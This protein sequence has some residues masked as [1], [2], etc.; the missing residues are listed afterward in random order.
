M[1]III[2]KDYRE[3]SQL[4]ANMVIKEMLIKE[5]II[6]G[7]ATGSSPIGLYEKLVDAYKSKIISFEHVSTF[8]L[9]EYI[10]LDREHPQSYYYFMNEHLFKHVDINYEK[11]NL[12]RSSMEH[13]DEI[14]NDYNTVLFGNQRDVQI[15]AKMHRLF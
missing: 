10:G 11:V 12:P 4:A 3:V 8:N 7:L 9:D 15:S 1:K 6:L 13:K 14:V 5:N 2:K